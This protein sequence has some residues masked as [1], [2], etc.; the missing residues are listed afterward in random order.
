[1][2]HGRKKVKII[3]D[4]GGGTHKKGGGVGRF[5][6]KTWGFA[7]TN[8]KKGGG[9]KDISCSVRGGGWRRN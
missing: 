3:R 7:S 1:M 2:G 5:H 4:F 6:Q 9:G 8:W